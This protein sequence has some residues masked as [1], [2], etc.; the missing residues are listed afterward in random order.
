MTRVMAWGRAGFCPCRRHSS[1]PNKAGPEA[2]S[3]PAVIDLGVESLERRGPARELNRP[4]R[5]GAQRVPPQR[6]QLFCRTV[7]SKARLFL[8]T[9]RAAPGLRSPML[10]VRC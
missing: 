8:Q 5:Q 7:I 9:S 4:R 3:P 1:G 6:G 10:T 2:Q